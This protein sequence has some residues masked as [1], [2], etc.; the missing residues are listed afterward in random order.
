MKEVTVLAQLSRQRGTS[1]FEGMSRR[2][3]QGGNYDTYLPDLL[4][5]WDLLLPSYLVADL[6]NALFTTE[7]K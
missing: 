6:S 5:G 7:P 4:S 2:D 1:S 3:R